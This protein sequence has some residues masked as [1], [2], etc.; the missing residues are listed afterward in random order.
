MQNW[1]IMASSGRSCAW[2]RVVKMWNKHCVTTR[3]SCSLS[4][5]I[6]MHIMDV[7]VLD[8]SIKDHFSLFSLIHLRPDCHYT[9]VG[10]HWMQKTSYNGLVYTKHYQKELT[11]LRKTTP[12][13]FSEAHYNIPRAC[14]LKATIARCD[15]SPRFFCM[16][17]H[18]YVNLKAI[19]YESTSL[20]RIVADKSHLVIVA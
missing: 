14:L 1:S 6:Y 2:L 7:F 19:R 5:C 16:M 20:H 13:D 11:E 9:P 18:Y 12:I 15:L 10:H 8:S 4:N 17:Q 3:K